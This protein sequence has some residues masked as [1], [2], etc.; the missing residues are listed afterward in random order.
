[1]LCSLL[2][3]SRQSFYKRQESDEENVSCPEKS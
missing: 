1:M 3:Y 2:G